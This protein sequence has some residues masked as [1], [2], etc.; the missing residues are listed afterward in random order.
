MAKIVFASGNRGKCV[1]VQAALSDLDW[2]IIPQSEL[3]VTSV[4]ETGL[5]F[6]ENA[7]I[8]ARHAAME[9]GLPA[10]ADDSG[11]VVDTLGG[12]PGIYSARYA[13][14]NPTALDNNNKLLAALK[15]CTDVAD[16]R[17]HF[18]CV[19]VYLTH[20]ADPMPA[21]GIGTWHG[22]IA[23]EPCGNEGHGYDPI[24]YLPER[25]CTA[26]ELSLAEKNKISHR[27]LALQALLSEIET[28]QVT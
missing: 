26:A 11:L 8:K 3:S 6:I 9:T 18:V 2:A 24:F 10:L 4:E 17:A 27:G 28:T 23:F 25:D 19:M 16:R 12:A 14:D 21:I 22:T 5:T 13:G 1:E 20:A 7:L 15:D